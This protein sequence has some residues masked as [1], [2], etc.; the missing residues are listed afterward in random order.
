MPIFRTLE[1]YP[2]TGLPEQAWLAN[3]DA[4]ALARA[5]VGVRELYS[6]AAAGLQLP[7]KSSRIRAFIVPEPEPRAELVVT[8]S[9]KYYEGFEMASWDA[10]AGFH[11]LPWGRRLRAVLDAAHTTLTAFAPHRGWD[12]GLLR[13]VHEQLTHAGLVLRWTSPWKSAPDR[14]HQA[15][16]RFAVREDGFGDA[17]VEIATRPGGH[18]VAA[19]PPLLA[20][21]SLPGWERAASTLQW[22]GSGRVELWPYVDFLGRTRGE[23]SLSIDAGVAPAAV[24]APEPD[25]VGEAVPIVVE[26]DPDEATGP[27]IHVMGGGPT[28]DVPDTYLDALH[29]LLDRMTGGDWVAWWSAADRDVLELWY[30]FEPRS[31]G[32]LVR[33]TKDAMRAYVQRRA[34]DLVG[35]PDPAGLARRDV[36]ELVEAIRARAGLPPPPPLD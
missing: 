13:Y 20:Y 8:V 15:R 11:R 1:T 27:A 7:A 17:V 23:A 26:P 22:D 9:T 24:V 18:V 5:A 2:P 25:G 19:S 29:D 16:V 21:C 31:T 3:A 32:P 14:R 36:E 10:P 35:E 34:R 28:N 12:V 30:R 33:R 6:R 4:D